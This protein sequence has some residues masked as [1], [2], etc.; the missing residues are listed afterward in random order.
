MS[1]EIISVTIDGDT[2]RKYKNTY[3]NVR[4]K[5]HAISFGRDNL[6]NY[7]WL[8][9]TKQ[10]A[11]IEMAQEYEMLNYKHTEQLRIEKKRLE[12]KIKYLEI[13]LNQIKNAKI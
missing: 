9:Y 4:K 5:L 3:D 12:E 13:E 8:F 11:L 7:D 6:I 10:Q 1:E 2:Y